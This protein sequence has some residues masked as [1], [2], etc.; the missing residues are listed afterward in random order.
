MQHNIFEH[1]VAV[2]GARCSTSGMSALLWRG[3]HGKIGALAFFR[4]LVHFF[5]W[6]RS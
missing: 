2:G 6:L 4:L 3:R 1:R 5:S